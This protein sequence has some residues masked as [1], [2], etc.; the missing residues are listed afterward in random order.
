MPSEL[1]AVI[2]DRIDTAR[3]R[4]SLNKLAKSA[5]V[6]YATLH[7]QFSRPKFSIDVLVALA[8]ALDTDLAELISEPDSASSRGGTGSRLSDCR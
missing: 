7:D 5:G 6:P 8:A 2:R 3:G 1:H 4:L